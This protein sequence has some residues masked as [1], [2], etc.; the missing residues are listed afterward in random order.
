LDPT[1]P[2]CVGPRK[3]PYHTI[4]PGFVTDDVGARMAF[5]VMGGPMQHQGHL[6]MVSRIFDFDQNPQA[7]SDAPRWHIGAEGAFEVA[8]ED[9]F[10]NNVAKGLAERGHR[11]VRGHREALFGGAQLVFGLRDGYCAA[12]DHRKEGAAAGF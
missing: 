2:N 1:H 3:R 10:P 12:S 6:Q 11:I 9:G 7:A 4:I 5:G 8:V